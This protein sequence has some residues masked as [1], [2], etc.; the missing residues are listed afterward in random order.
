MIEPHLLD[1]ECLDCKL[2]AAGFL[3]DVERVKKILEPVCRERAISFAHRVDEIEIM[4]QTMTMSLA[5]QVV[6]TLRPAPSVEE[7]K[8]VL[9]KYNLQ[10]NIVY[11]L[12]IGKTFVNRIEDAAQEI[13]DL[14]KEEKK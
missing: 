10:D 9:Q 11:D 2:R 13:A 1:C 8:K 6:E 4:T 12:I 7:I 14:G 3:R 5:K